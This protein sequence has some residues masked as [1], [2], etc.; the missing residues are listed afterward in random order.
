MDV[1]FFKAR[2]TVP[3]KLFLMEQTE[4]FLSNEVVGQFMESMSE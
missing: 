3:T 4:K 2:S 1:P